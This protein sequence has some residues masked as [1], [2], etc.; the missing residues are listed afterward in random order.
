MR[1][2]TKRNGIAGFLLLFGILGMCGACSRN[3]YVIPQRET[4]A[5]Q[6]KFAQQQEQNYLN[7]INKDR[8]EENGR[9]AIAAYRVVMKR[10]P[11][12]KVYYPQ[13]Q[14][15]IAFILDREKKTGAALRMYNHMIKAYPDNSRILADSLYGAAVIYDK[16]GK[17]D[18]AQANYERIIK[19]FGKDK[20]YDR[21][22][23][24]SKARYNRV[25]K[26]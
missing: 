4:A 17:Y 21:L 8:H 25:R 6:F 7:V 13:S 3:S 2:L 20:E 11:D 24:A 18:K 10:F 14:Y 5:Q 23:V 19:E 15:K 26:K 1:D 9:Q 22:V 12:D 16:A